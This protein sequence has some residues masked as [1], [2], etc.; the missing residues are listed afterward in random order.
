[1]KKSGLFILTVV[2]I[3][4]F[5]GLTY[6]CETE[7]EGFINMPEKKQENMNFFIQE[8]GFTADELIGYDLEKI[9]IDYN[10]KSL[11]YSGEEVRQ[12]LNES[13][14]Y[15]LDDGTTELFQIFSAVSNHE[16]KNESELIK[17]GYY[18]N[19]GTFVEYVV[20]DL[21]ERCF[22]VNTAEPNP[23]SEEQCKALR[24]LPERWGILDWDEDYRGEEEPS[25]GSLGWKLVLSYQDLSAFV[26]GGY[27]Q[28][29]T[30]LPVTFFDMN[31]ELQKIIREE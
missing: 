13:G 16:K 10:L 17:I 14:N 26:S 18:Y 19:S 27:T 2:W 25:T 1:M 22:Y 5:T 11:D 6:T 12:I 23:L 15:Y 9:I 31:D 24:E 28:D 20:F 3:C 29:H 4:L 8:Y 30:H 21:E 7:S